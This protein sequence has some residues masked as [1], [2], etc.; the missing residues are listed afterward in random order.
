[1]N[2]HI[3]ITSVDQPTHCMGILIKFKDENEKEYHTYLENAEAAQFIK[4][5]S[6]ILMENLYKF[7]EW[8]NEN[9]KEE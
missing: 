8:I 7:N 5:I 2:K 9:N 3:F 4:E 6:E 1:M